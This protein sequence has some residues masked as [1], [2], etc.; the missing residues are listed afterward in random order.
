MVAKH[1]LDTGDARPELALTIL[2][3]ISSK[4]KSRGCR[5]YTA[6]INTKKNL[7][8]VPSRVGCKAYLAE[9]DQHKD[10]RQATLKLLE[11]AKEEALGLF[12]KEGGNTGGMKRGAEVEES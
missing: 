6:Y 3:R 9:K 10:R 7:S 2:G 11:F 8:D 1:W 5:L 4:L 12:L